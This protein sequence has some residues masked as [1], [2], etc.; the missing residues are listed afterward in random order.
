M[1]VERSLTQVFR[2][3]TYGTDFDGRGRT[4]IASVS[5]CLQPPGRLPGLFVE[6]DS[7]AMG[8]EHQLQFPMSIALV[9]MYRSELARSGRREVA[10]AETVTKANDRKHKTRTAKT[11]GV[12]LFSV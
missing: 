4:T 8:T 11:L 10:R 6:F 9:H 5:V 3:K 1:T 2:K 7:R 12:E